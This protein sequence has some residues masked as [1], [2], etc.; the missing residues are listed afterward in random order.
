MDAWRM[1]GLVIVGQKIN[2]LVTAGQDDCTGYTVVGERMNGW[3][4]V[5][6][7]G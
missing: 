6:Q 1:N 2:E 3:F 7:G 5:G 4:R